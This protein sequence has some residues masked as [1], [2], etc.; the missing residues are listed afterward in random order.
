MDQNAA[1]MASCL[2]EVENE[3]RVIRQQLQSQHQK[4]QYYCQQIQDRDRQTRPSAFL[5]HVDN[6]HSMLYSKLSVESNPE[7]RSKGTTTA[8]HDKARPVI[9][10]QW[11]GFPEKQTALFDEISNAFS[12]D[13]LVF[14]RE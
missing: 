12:T 5:E 6:C 10:K 7:L 13:H 4:I 1:S 14:L 2:Q 3:M 8:I 11:I 9:V